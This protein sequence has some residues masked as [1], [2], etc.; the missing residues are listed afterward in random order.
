MLSTCIFIP[1]IDPFLYLLGISVDAVL[2]EQIGQKGF[3]RQVG[4]L[5]GLLQ[6]QRGQHV[7]SPPLPCL[8]KLFLT[9]K[10]NWFH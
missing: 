2:R 5:P 7:S 6:E 10:E 4:P 3:L 9:S 8:V 1:Y